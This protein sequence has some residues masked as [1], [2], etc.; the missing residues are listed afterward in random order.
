MGVSGRQK[1]WEGKQYVPNRVGPPEGAKG[2]FTLQKI[3][4]TIGWTA[5]PHVKY[6]SPWTA[7]TLL[8]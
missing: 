5:A 6:V 4:S 3:P 1:Y 8:Q 7:Q 2:C